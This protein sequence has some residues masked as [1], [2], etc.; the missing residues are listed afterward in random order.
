MRRHNL[1]KRLLSNLVWNDIYSDNAFFQRRGIDKKGI[2]NYMR[3]YLLTVIFIAASCFGA[4]SLGVRLL[5]RYTPCS[6]LDIVVEGNTGYV[7]NSSGGLMVLDVANPA[8]ISSPGYQFLPG[9]ATCIDIIGDYVAIACDD[10]ALRILDPAV[11]S[12]I[13]TVGEYSGAFD[14]A[15]CFVS[16]DTVFTTGGRFALFSANPPSEIILMCEYS[17]V[18]AAEDIFVQ[19]PYAYLAENNYGLSIIDIS[20]PAVPVNFG[21]F[22]GLEEYVRSVFVDRRNRIYIGTNDELMIYRMNGDS[23]EHLGSWTAP[24][25]VRDIEVDGRYAFLACGNSG[26]RILD[27]NSPPSISEVGYYV[28]GSEMTAIHLDYPRIWLVGLWARINCF[29]VSAFANIDEEDIPKPE[30]SSLNIFPSPFN[31]E[32]RIDG[33]S[34]RALVYD[35]FGS[36]VGKITI[37]GTWRPEEHS[38]SGFYLIQPLNAEGISTGR[39]LLMR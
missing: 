38:P 19:H 36:Q 20:N 29:D 4:D 28:L 5:G 21:R 6:P 11:P 37:P 9:E 8:S 24:A 30:K 13:L 32:C 39:V 15:E 18:F 2:G 17:T 23:I 27:V 16:G 33:P 7:A 14:I 34:C 26:L 22:F 35:V 3:K 31:S 25:P 12:D 1:H 10:N